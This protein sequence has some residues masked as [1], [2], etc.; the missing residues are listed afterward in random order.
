MRKALTILLFSV[1]YLIVFENDGMAQHLGSRTELFTIEN[2]LSQTE[3]NHILRDSKGYLWLATKDGLDRYDGNS[4]YIFRHQPSDSNSIC[5]NYVRHLCEDHNG[6]IW[7]ATINGLSIY[8]PQSGVFTNFHNDPDDANSISDNSLFFVYED[9]EGIMWVKTLASLEK[10]DIKGKRFV[11]YY[12]YN[13]VFNYY[14]GDYFF[15]I[16]EDRNGKLWVG[17]KDGLNCFDKNLELFERFEYNK[18]DPN[19][20]SD[21]RIKSISEDVEGGL[22]IGTENGLNYYDR[23]IK[24]FKRFYNIPFNNNSLINNVVN[25]I[26]S[27]KKGNIWLGTQKGFCN[28]H[29]NSGTFDQFSHIYINNSK[30]FLFD[31]NSIIIDSAD[32][33]W[34]GSHQGLVKIDTKPF[35]FKVYRN[36]KD[37]IDEK[38]DISVTSLYSDEQD[39]IWIGTWGKG[40]TIFNR[41]NKLI[42]TYT[43]ETNREFL[44]NDNISVIYPDKNNKIWIGTSSGMAFFDKAIGQFSNACNLFRECTFLENNRIYTIFQDR[45]GIIWIGTEHGLHTFNY[46]GNVIRNF[47]QIP[48][49][50]GIIM[51]TVYCI[52]EDT[53]GAL[54]FGTNQGLVKF[55]PKTGK[56]KKYES[57]PKVNIN[58]LSNN[59]IYSLL[60]SSK[61]T[62]WVGTTS[63][64]CRYNDQSDNFTFY[65]ED[66]GLPNNLIYAIL[67]DSS[68]N[69]WLSTNKGIV[70]Y[71]VKQEIF[72]GY[73]MTDGLQ[74]YEFNIASAYKSRNG[75]M[76][77]GGIDGFNSFYP[78]S[79]K[80]TLTKPNV[81]ITSID[82]IGRSFRKKIP[83]WPDKEV[84]IPS[85]T[86]VF[87]I[88]FA[89]LDFTN[90]QNNQYMYMM[91]SKTKEGLWINNG[92]RNYIS[93]SNLPAGRYFFHVKG[94]NSDKIWGDKEYSI[95][96]VVE[97]PFWTTNS[98]IFLYIFFLISIGYGAVQWRTRKLRQTNKM[99]KEKELAAKEIARQK[100]E[101]TIKNKNITDSINY[102]KRIQV[103]MMP[104][105]KTFKRLL[106]N[107][108]VYHKPRDIVSGD[109]YW[110]FER[111]GKVFVA[112]VDCTGHGVPGAFMSILG[113]EL[114]RKI[115]LNQVENPG[116]IL[117]K[118]NEDFSM[119]F[120][121]IEDISL[122]DGMDISFCVIDKT[123][124]KMDFAGAFNPLYIIRDNKIIEIKG[125][126][127][128]VSME[129]KQEAPDF[130]THKIA[131]KDKDMIYI[132]SDGY[133]DQ[134]GGYEGKKFKYRR[135]RHMLLNIHKLPLEDQK[136]Y[137]EE[138]M[139][140]WK[141][142]HDQVDDILVIG[143]RADF[144]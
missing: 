32:I 80:T 93:F 96:I 121:D 43:S 17:S 40:L 113:V 63:G 5:D 15:T 14:S 128:S 94:A 8:N 59:T 104:S 98:A 71:N 6:N 45:L 34:I 46:T 11:H 77:F 120:S 144:N 28:Y 99:L 97:S 29:L 118:I 33:L 69:L 54:W 132:F 140:A 51:N 87:I 73:N 127:F 105:E 136:A 37:N 65:T 86:N 4:F 111:E 123:N 13:N 2:G 12:H 125:N 58:S 95:N 134:F 74:S 18:A 81:E 68:G 142:N 42:K 10:F 131:L 24:K 103:A 61:H 21:N 56:Y 112:A 9:H 22:W 84:H 90:P 119:I 49:S 35:K 138:S 7:I 19:S 1:A 114:F 91:T 109:F 3:I 36:F 52:I 66:D 115:T 116:M 23:R 88:N 75:E 76:F 133:A 79:L 137:L 102:A 64:L 31:V 130:E 110:I 83:V 41:K 117:S 30:L 143:I 20:I 92:N 107:S 62:I 53:S 78:D 101:L 26:Y 108:F 89:V 44:N 82:I 70:F 141:G 50:Q 106:P 129:K 122:K 55:N 60:Y 39:K 85:G 57:D 25:N 27:D 100:E 126:R 38:A 48:D 16:L 139:M 47:V 72:N 135:F 67:E 124:N